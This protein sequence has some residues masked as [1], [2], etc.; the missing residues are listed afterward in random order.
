M[1]HAQEHITHVTVRRLRVGASPSQVAFGWDYPGSTVLE[2]RIL[3][4]QEGFAE[5]P[6]DAEHAGAH[7]A[8]VFQGYAGS[9]RDR[10]VVPGERYLYTVFARDRS[11]PWLVWARRGVRAARPRFVW[12]RAWLGHC[13]RG[14]AR[15]LRRR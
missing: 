2:V 14:G 11:G 8:L 1:S 6:Y 10:G 13:A 12:L 7:Q 15:A 9:F 4:S 5:T 3:R